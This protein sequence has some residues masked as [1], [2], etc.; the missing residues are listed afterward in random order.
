M[1]LFGVSRMLLFF[2]ANPRFAVPPGPIHTP[3]RKNGEETVEHSPRRRQIM[4]VPF[5]RQENGTEVGKAW[6]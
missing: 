6:C 1:T 5:G 3:S 2:A 4:R